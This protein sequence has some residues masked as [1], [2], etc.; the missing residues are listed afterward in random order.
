[1]DEFQSFLRSIVGNTLTA[2]QINAL[3]KEAKERFGLSDKATDELMLCLVIFG[4]SGLD[5]IFCEAN[6]EREKS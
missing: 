5:Y 1:M 4:K 3:G 6:K 2:E